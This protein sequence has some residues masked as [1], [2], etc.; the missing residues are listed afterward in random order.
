MGAAPSIQ[1]IYRDATK[2]FNS[3]IDKA[4]YV[5]LFEILDKD[6][7]GGISFQELQ[8]WIKKEALE[9]PDSMFTS[10]QAHGLI[11]MLA[12][13][14]AAKRT[15]V[16]SSVSSR[17]IVDICEF[18]YLLI[19][20]YALSMIYRHFNCSEVWNG[21]VHANIDHLKKLDD[22]GF[23][24]AVQS[25]YYVRCGE[26]LSDAVVTS[27]FLFLDSDYDGIVGFVQVFHLTYVQALGKIISTVLCRLL[28]CVPV[29]LTRYHPRPWSPLT[30]KL[31]TRP[32]SCCAFLEMQML[33]TWVS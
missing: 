16:S 7:D 15:D 17:N 22:A 30:R 20:L 27:D 21:H 25:L 6:M 1:D 26:I 11:S 5:G 32:R 13:K 19:H 4:T 12:H 8:V 2:W 29:M 18:R 24:V 31:L 10:F 3:Y 33:V 14:A 9:N 23:A 28:L